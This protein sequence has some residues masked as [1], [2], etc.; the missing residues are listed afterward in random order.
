[1]TVR[2]AKTWIP[3]QTTY[4]GHW[5]NLP[6]LPCCLHACT[7]YLLHGQGPPSLSALTFPQCWPEEGKGEE[8]GAFARFGLLSFPE[9]EGVENKCAPH[10]IL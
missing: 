7:G 4:L 10:P 1:M 8:E 5:E 3:R 9:K 2:T 6:H